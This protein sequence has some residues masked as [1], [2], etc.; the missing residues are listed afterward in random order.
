MPKAKV[1]KDMIVEAGFMIVRDEG[2]NMLNVRNVASILG[3]STQPVMYCYPTVSEMKS[4]VLERAN[5]FHTAYLI[6]NRSAGE[7]ILLSIGMNY[8]RFAYH[9]KHLFRFIVMSDKAQA[10]G[11][12][13]LITSDDSGMLDPLARQK[14]LTTEQMKDVFEALFV[15]FHG[16]ATLVSQDALRFDELHCKRQ[17]MRIYDGV[18]DRVRE[19]REFAEI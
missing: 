17:L 10:G 8:I 16:Y 18:T 5:E 6:Q 2:E 19:S 13:E 11:I 14:G 12:S 3:C 1:T 15:S 9:E 4:A 7:D